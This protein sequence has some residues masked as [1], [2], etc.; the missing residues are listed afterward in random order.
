MMKRSEINRWIQEAIDLLDKI[1]W[2]LPPFA[3]WSPNIWKSIITSPEEKARH[4]PIFE[5]GLGWDLSDFGSGDFF[6]MGL[7]LFTMRN[8]KIGTSREYAEK[9]MIS[10]E[11]QITPWHFHWQ[12]TEDI[13]NRGGGN[14]I[15][16][17]YHASSTDNLKPGQPFEKGEYD[18]ES[19]VELLKDGV[20]NF[21]SPG[22]KVCLKP[23]ESLALPP[24]LYHT[25]YGEPG[26]GTVIV[27]EISKVN[28][29]TLD[30]RFY[31]E[32]PRFA[33]IIEDGPAKFV[34]CNEYNLL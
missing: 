1:S 33:K 22:D 34:L 11:G 9:I 17:V 2:K 15:I 18:L 7:L 4:Q 28:D 12:K 30:N 21:Y 23:G 6:K 25:F 27:G 19:P 13:I 24:R 8:G 16:E 32:L 5:Q 26:Y 14:L 20:L 10:R 3:F 31:Q 29:D